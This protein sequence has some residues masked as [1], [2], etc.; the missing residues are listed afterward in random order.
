M[1]NKIEE[2]EGQKRLRE[3]PLDKLLR[4]YNETALRNLESIMDEGSVAHILDGPMSGPTD[5]NYH[6]DAEK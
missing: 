5:I 1:N 4:E 6:R 3:S 2:T